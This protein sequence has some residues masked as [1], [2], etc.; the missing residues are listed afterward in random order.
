MRWDQHPHAGTIAIYDCWYFCNL[1]SKK[2]ETSLSRRHMIGDDLE[3]LELLGI[4]TLP[5]IL[6]WCSALRWEESIQTGMHWRTLL[7]FPFS[8]HN[9]LPLCCQLCCIRCTTSHVLRP[10]NLGTACAT[11]NVCTCT[12]IDRNSFETGRMALIPARRL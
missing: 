2:I 10:R 4:Q 7:R 6:H 9:H 1:D 11:I 3:R 12:Y 8:V 5:G